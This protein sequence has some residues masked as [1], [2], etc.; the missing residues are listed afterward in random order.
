MNISIIM[1]SRR[2][3]PISPISTVLK[4]RRGRWP[5]GRRLPATGSPDTGVAEGAW[6]VAFQ[7]PEH[8]G[9]QQQG[10]GVISS[11]SFAVQFQ[12][13]QRRLRTSVDDDA[14]KPIPGSADRRW[15]G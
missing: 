11:T 3:A 4:P 13:C 2:R 6:V 5:T 15:S 8:Q 9:P 10:R 14:G 7:Q 1:N 12:L